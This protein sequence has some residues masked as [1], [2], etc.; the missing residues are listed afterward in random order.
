VNESDV[1]F[2]I[3]AV[4]RIRNIEALINI[5]NKIN[6]ENTDEGKRVEQSNCA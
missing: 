1:N 2:S 4:E 6:N 5:R 3:N